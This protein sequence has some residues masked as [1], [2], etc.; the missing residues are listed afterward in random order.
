MVHILLEFLNVPLIDCDP[1]A[2]SG[3]IICECGSFSRALILNLLATLSIRLQLR[4]KLLELCEILV[5]HLSILHLNDVE[6]L[7][8]LLAGVSK[9][10]SE[11]IS[12]L[13]V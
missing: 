2:K 8:V 5:L 13:C 11:L 4:L 6:L 3:D 12:L 10:I 9:A 7:L 1:L